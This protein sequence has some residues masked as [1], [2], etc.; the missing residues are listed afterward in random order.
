MSTDD[1]IVFPSATSLHQTLLPLLTERR[2]RVVADDQIH[3]SMHEALRACKDVDLHW[4]R[5]NDLAAMES[6]LRDCPEG[7]EKLLLADGVYSLSGRIAPLQR[8]YSMAVENDALLYL[9]DSH[10]FGV[11]GRH[12]EGVPHLLHGERENLIYVGSLSK[13]I[14]CYGGFAATDQDLGTAI[15]DYCGGIMFSG[16]LPAVLLAGAVA[17]T[18]F[19]LSPQLS[20]IQAGLWENQRRVVE[21]VRNTGWQPLSDESPIVCVD[22]TDAARVE[23]IVTCMREHQVLASVVAFPAVPRGHLRIRLSVSANHTTDDIEC[24]SDALQAAHNQANS[25]VGAPIQASY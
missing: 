14:G 1:A 21:A 17:A 22:F 11:F 23:A 5:H 12:G 20:E 24:L 8:L 4:I 19:L 25:S 10:G 2:T 7:T 9:D 3:H 18:E 13:A 15:R 6:H 16:P